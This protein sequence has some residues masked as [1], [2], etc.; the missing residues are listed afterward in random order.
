[1]SA[2]NAAIGYYTFFKYH[3]DPLLLH[4][5]CFLISVVF[6][7]DATPCSSRVTCGA[8]LASHNCAWCSDKVYQREHQD[9]VPLSDAGAVAGSAIQ[10]KPQKLKLSLRPGDPATFKV[11]FR[12]A[13]D[14]PVDLYYLMD[15]TFTMKK[16]K[17]TLAELA[18]TIAESMNNVTKN[19][20]LGFGSFIDKVVMPYVDMVPD[21][22][23]N[24]C[25]DVYCNSPYGFRNHLSLN[26]DVTLFT[27][28]VSRANLSGNLDNA[29][30]KIKWN[31]R[32]RK[33]ILFAT[34]GIFHY[35]GDGKLGGIVKPND[36][37]CHL[38]DE[39]YYT[40]SIY[41]DY[42]SLSQINNKI[43]ENKILIIFAVP[44]T[45]LPLYQRLTNH[46]E[47]T[48]AEKLESDASNIV[49]LIQQ[50]YN[51]IQSKVELK[52]TAPDFVKISYSSSCLGENVKDVNYCEG[53]K[54]GWHCGF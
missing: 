54:S 8:C 6:S 27:K 28:E 31:D 23:R 47:G 32:S 40:E 33:I 10:L 12:Q 18:D 13:E 42:P 22:L 44:D 30:G 38:D 41:Q 52:D 14:Y 51:K 50:Q 17:E 21:R 1:M 29:E 9:N 16:H 24:P 7:E 45:E 39:G 15:L 26:D 46:V 3:N 11:T 35:A 49:D 2:L 37:S 36:G 34:D 19:F 48:Y 53:L 25:R 5:Y 4:H 20:R 43:I